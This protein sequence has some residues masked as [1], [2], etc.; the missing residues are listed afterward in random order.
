MGDD[1][2]TYLRPSVSI[3]GWV[4]GWE[5]G[6][7]GRRWLV[8]GSWWRR[9]SVCPGERG[10]GEMN[11]EIDPVGIEKKSMAIIAELVGE[12]EWSLGEKAIIYRLVHTSG[13]PEYAELAV[14]HPQAIEAG[15]KALKGGCEIITDVKMVETGI[16]KRTLSKLGV[17]TRCF[18]D[19]PKSREIARETGETRSMT[20]I[21]LAEKEIAGNI[22]AIG[23]APTALF[24][25]LELCKIKGIKPA[26]IVGTPVGF[27]GAAESKELL[28]RE[29]PVPY[30]TI[31]GSK[32]GSPVA[33]SII[34][35]L[36]YSLVER[37]EWKAS[38][39]FPL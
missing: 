38:L 18:L 20:G 21:K 26:L 29:E 1:F 27:V 31:S 30:I 39:C 34:N 23:N 13:D 37:E 25:L 6:W 15:Q 7:G 22:I 14:I 9:T 4:L 24:A 10:D 11:Y 16:N 19:N 17:K 33:A 28:I 36:A 5:A 12:R 35:A 3:R 2:R 32:G 8:F